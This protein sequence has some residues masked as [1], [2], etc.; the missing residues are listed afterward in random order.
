M[1]ELEKQFTF[2]SGHVLVHHDGKCRQPHG[3]SYT[4]IVQVASP[5]LIANGPKTNM[6]IDF[7]DI[8]AIVC[9]MIENYFDHKWLNDSLNTDSPT[10]EFMAK[11]IYEFLEEKLPGLAA[12][13]LH[14]TY[15]SKV[16]YRPKKI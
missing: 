14:E 3:H 9:P 12:I 4:L 13:T 1:F 6:V 15:S 8:S 2:E 10:V 7:N 5:T 16:T 11:W